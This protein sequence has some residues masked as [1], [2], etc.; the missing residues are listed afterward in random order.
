M[1]TKTPTL[2]IADVASPPCATLA[3]G[4]RDRKSRSINLLR[5]DRILSYAILACGLCTVGVGARQIITSHS[6]VPLWDEWQE[7]DAIVTAPNHQPAISWLWSLHNEHRVV[8][9]RLLLLADIQ[10]FHGKHW[11]SLWSMLVVQCLFLV[12]LG[13]MVHFAGVRGTLWRAIVGLGAFV[14]FCPSQWENFGWAF[15]I[16]FLLP[17]FFLL[18]A[19]SALLKYE[20]SIREFRPKWIYLTLSIAAASAA[21]YANANGVVLWPLLILAATVLVPRPTVIAPYVGFAALLIGSYLYHYA[22]PAIHSSPLDSIR[23]P[24][25]VLEFTAGYLGVIFPAW[26]RSRN[27][28]AVSSGAVGLFVA[29]TVT[30]WVLKRQRR[31]PLQIALV[32]LMF[33]ALFTAFITA[34]GRIN[35]GLA[36]A[37]SSRYQTFNLLFWFSTVSLLILLANEMHSPLRTAILAATS[38]AMV[39]AFAVFPLGLKASRTRIQQAEAA[40]TA[41]LAGVPEKGALAVLFGEPLLVWRD[42][43]YFRQQH[44]FLFSD[45]TNEQMGR[46]LSSTYRVGPSSQCKGRAIVAERIPAD[47]LLIGNDTRALRL[48]GFALD[49]LSNTPEQR[50]IIAADDRIVGYGAS[51]AGPF[52]A[53]HSELVRKRDPGEW[54]GFARPPEGATFL[55]VFAVNKSA[56]TVCRLATVEVPQQ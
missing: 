53:K 44:L 6:L 15:Q 31:E 35:F 55:D 13:W 48:S 52:A 5:A 2:A 29:L 3:T 54:L 25:A 26:I 49:E 30:L 38:T 34:L 22:G 47:N 51:I 20:Q 33:F 4:T 39:L 41:L 27:L 17:G 50:L 1:D 19:L 7:I 23:H 36:E 18:L 24:L 32:A 8:F 43:A 42:G 21:T 40:A 37:F 9:Y 14:L 11:I 56:G 12:T 45:A 10:L 28:L 16:S 46:L